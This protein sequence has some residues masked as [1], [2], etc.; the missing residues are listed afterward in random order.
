MPKIVQLKNLNCSS[1]GS[2]D[3]SS[4]SSCSSKVCPKISKC[5]LRQCYK[6][7]NVKDAVNRINLYLT[8]QYAELVSI[9]APNTII[10]VPGDADGLLFYAGVYV[11]PTQTAPGGTPGL[12]QLLE[13][14]STIATPTGA[15][16]ITD[17]LVNCSYTQV[18]IFTTSTIT[19]N[20]P[21]TPATTTTITSPTLYIFYYDS[22]G[23]VQK[24][25]IISQNDQL[26]PFL[27][28]CPT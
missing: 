19:Y 18:A 13:S 7:K 27:A 2:S 3:S 23:V 17:V 15:G 1:S 5:R 24:T 10:T 16:E 8:G 11:G 12:A 25:D 4:S 26:I 6:N 28:S 22:N 14:Y 21:S 9:T 20:C